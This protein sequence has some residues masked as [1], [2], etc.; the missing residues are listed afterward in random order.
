MKD[1]REAALLNGRLTMAALALL[2]SQGT[3]VDR[4]FPDLIKNAPGGSG[5]P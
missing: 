1:A 3:I 5:A 4:M 2:V